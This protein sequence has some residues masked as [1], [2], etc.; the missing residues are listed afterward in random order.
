MASQ[1]LNLINVLLSGSETYTKADIVKE[2]KPQFLGL[3]GLD[4]LCH[5]DIDTPVITI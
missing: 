3:G 1:A 4:K 2:Y 5:I